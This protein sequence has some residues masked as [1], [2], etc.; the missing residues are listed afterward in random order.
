M[1]IL[2]SERNQVEKAVGWHLCALAIRLSIDVPQVRI[3]LRQ[4]GAH[5]AALGRDQFHAL[6]TDY[7][8]AEQA[9]TVGALL[10]QYEAPNP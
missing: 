4:L 2:A 6:V 7:T 3:D 1:G 10:D 9:D 5:R 8:D